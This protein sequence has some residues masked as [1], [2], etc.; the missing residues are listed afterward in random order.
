MSKPYLCPKCEGRGGT[1]L[2]DICPVCKGAMILWSPE[3][4][5]VPCDPLPGWPWGEQPV[6]VPLVPGVLYT[7]PTTCNCNT[8]E[9]P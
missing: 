1:T 3:P 9:K 8:S 7:V 2:D 5:P 6:Y 4:D